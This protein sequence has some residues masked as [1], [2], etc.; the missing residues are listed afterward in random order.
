MEKTINIGLRHKFLAF[1]LL[2]LIVMSICFV[3]IGYLSAKSSKENLTEFLLLQKLEANINS[4][5]KYYELYLSKNFPDYDVA[6][7]FKD[8]KLRDNTELVDSIAKDLSVLATIFARENDD[9][10][11]ISTSILT[12]D[13]NR[14]VGTFLGKESLAYEPLIKGERYIGEVVILGKNY[15]AV[16]DPVFDAA[17]NVI[18]IFFVGVSDEDATKISDESSSNLLKSFV[19]A[20]LVLLILSTIATLVFTKRIINPLSLLAKQGNIIA[21]FDFTEDVSS[22]L[23]HRQDEI[24][25]L[26]KALQNIVSSFRVV[27]KGINNSAEILLSSSQEL[28]S[29][30][31]QSATAADE[32]ARAIEDIANG[33]LVTRLRTW[34]K[35]EDMLVS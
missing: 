14:A 1:I 30:S 12:A 24:G 27:I 26:S 16:Y 9:F 32:I 5:N 10:I 4:I 35:E 3:A 29:T 23:L 8:R 2:M 6:T 19:I 20:I 31:Q 18:G 21:N 17:G 7:S 34:S 11:R 13:G 25:V 33:A 15:H 28:T 22:N